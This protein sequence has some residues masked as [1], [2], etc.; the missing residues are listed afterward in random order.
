MC[1]QVRIRWYSVVT[2]TWYFGSMPL[3]LSIKVC[4]CR[5]IWN[6]SLYFLQIL[7]MFLVSSEVALLKSHHSISVKF[8]RYRDTWPTDPS[9]ILVHC[10]E[11]LHIQ[12]VHTITLYQ[13]SI[14][15]LYV[16]ISTLYWILTHCK[17]EH[18]SDLYWIF[19]QLHLHRISPPIDKN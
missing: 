7:G 19:V 8:S 13:L 12:N 5:K 9:L 17:Y 1:W 2:K 14:H 11:S 3:L 6:K 10:T 4:K 16:H 15:S 18:T